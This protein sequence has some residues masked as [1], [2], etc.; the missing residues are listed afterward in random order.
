MTEP[1]R[2]WIS[3][4]WEAYL[5]PTF[6]GDTSGYI[7]ADLARTPLAEALAVVTAK[8]EEEHRIHITALGRDPDEYS[9]LF[10]LALDR[11]NS[12]IKASGRRA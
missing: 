12:A 4:K 5:R 6:D 1:D 9:S 3:E 11:L 2:I 8:L 10:S 7:R